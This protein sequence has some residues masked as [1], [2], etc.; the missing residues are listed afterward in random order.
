MKLKQITLKSLSIEPD[1]KP[2]E[3]EQVDKCFTS[4]WHGGIISYGDVCYSKIQFADLLC[5]LHQNKH[6]NDDVLEKAYNKYESELLKM[7][8]MISETLNCIQQMM[9]K[10]E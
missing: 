10:T 9:K 7:F 8:E 2:I 3:I 5:A 6:L 1:C 4:V